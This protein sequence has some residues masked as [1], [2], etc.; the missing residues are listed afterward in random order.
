MYG[1]HEDVPPVPYAPQNAPRLRATGDADRPH[2][3]ARPGAPAPA[4]YPTA[5]E[6]AAH[7]LG[8]ACALVLNAP[9]AAAGLLRLIDEQRPDPEGALVLAALLHITGR[10]DAARSWWHFAAGAGSR[11][12][13]YALFLDHRRRGE[14][15]DAKYWRAQ[16]AKLATARPGPRPEPPGPAAPSPDL[17]PEE[18][19]HSLL[20]Q[21][22][23][24]L[25]PHL[26]RALAEVVDRVYRR[27][28]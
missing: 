3:P 20:A 15:R 22:H 10:H 1:K 17:L 6:Q 27:E 8:L 26:P 13:A 9:Q 19:R 12:A 28:G 16:S 18:A 11:T 2:T 5:Y 24:G 25:P 23:H 14:Y 7:E 4:P 21:L